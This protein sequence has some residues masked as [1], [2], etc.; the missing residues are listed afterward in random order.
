MLGCL[1]KIAGAEA[2]ILPWTFALPLHPRHA[3]VSSC[4]VGKMGE[5]LLE[6]WPLTFRGWRQ[7]AGMRCPFVAGGCWQADLVLIHD[8]VVGWLWIRRLKTSSGWFPDPRST[9]TC[10]DL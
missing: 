2:E 4:A 3:G 8:I 10:G 7:A 6:L 5:G 1:G 9:A